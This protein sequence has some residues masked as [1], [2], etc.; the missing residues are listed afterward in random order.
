MMDGLMCRIDNDN[1]VITISKEAL[2]CAA[3]YHPEMEDDYGNRI[4][5]ITDM[6]VFAE[7]ICR[8]LQDEE[9]DG[10][11]LIHKMFDE[12]ISVAV[13]DGCEGCEIIEHEE[14]EDEE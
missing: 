6:N 7:E 4:L 9:E 10:T 11:T 1:V 8:Q 14:E 5:K 3:E 13:D 12:A 2:K